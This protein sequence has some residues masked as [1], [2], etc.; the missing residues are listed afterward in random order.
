MIE[1]SYKN[2]DTLVIKNAD[3]KEVF[4]NYNDNTV[5]LED[6]DVTQP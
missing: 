1:I 2:E 3:K 5:H 6:F 4:F